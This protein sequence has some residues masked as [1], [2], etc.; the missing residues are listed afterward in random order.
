MSWSWNPTRDDG[1]YVQRRDAT[2][3][4]QILGDAVGECCASCCSGIMGCV[5]NMMESA[6][7]DFDNGRYG[8]CCIKS[9]CSLITGATI[10]VIAVAALVTAAV[11][12]SNGDAEVC[13]NG[14]LG[15]QYCE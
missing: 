8:R 11:A 5:S 15:F 13:Y 6:S 12:I 9:T 3:S 14:F 7:R 4:E 2:L 1:I 10:A